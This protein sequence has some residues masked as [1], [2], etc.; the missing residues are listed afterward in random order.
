M[1]SDK[2]IYKII[3]VAMEN[4]ASDIHMTYGLS[5]IIRIDG[6]LKSLH[7]FKVNDDLILNSLKD[8]LLNE[9]LSI[10]YEKYKNVDLSV[11]YK[12]IRLR[13]HVYRQKDHNT[14]SL[15]LISREIPKLEE[16][17]LPETL[18]QFTKVK[19]GLVL[20][21]GVTG[22][23]K[24]TTLAS[25]I[26]EINRKQSKHII[27]VEDPIEYLHEHK[28]SIVNQREVGSDVLNFSD[29]VIAAMRED[30]DI[31]LLGELRDLDTI[32]NA[33]TMAETGHLVFSTLHTR[34]VPES[35]DRIIDVFPANQQ[36][37]IRIQLSNS[38][39]GIIAQELL[40]M[41]GGGR[42]PC[43]EIMIV[44]NAIRNLIREKASP[45]AMLDQIHMN[46]K[47]L[48]SQT[49]VQ[50][51]GELL[52]LGKISEEVA[53]NELSDTEQETLQRVMR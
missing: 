22:S 45:S 40:P 44:N 53:M 2:L 13:I 35:I 20:V 16:I 19:N 47:K 46:N 18:R 5:P 34:S 17:N 4:K 24:S 7:E 37:Q 48:G 8:E 26:D 14:F 33:I 21:T 9:E 51:L 29:A 12:D 28:A 10:R 43:C 27:T 15:R 49:R 6:E 52:K 3:D 25:L 11:S 30:P 32:R 41:E 38:I 39:E 23:G 31:L 42:V 1:R 36:D 50:A